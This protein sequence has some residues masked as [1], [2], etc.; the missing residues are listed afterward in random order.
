MTREMLGR[1]QCDS[2]GEE[3]EVFRGK[4]KSPAGL[5]ANCGCGT[6]YHWVGGSPAAEQ[7]EEELKKA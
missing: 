3:I 7:L 5:Y 2:C 4:R 6:R 1:V